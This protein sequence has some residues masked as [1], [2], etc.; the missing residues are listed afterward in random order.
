ML[1]VL[2]LR[3]KVS[4]VLLLAA[5]ATLVSCAHDKDTQLVSDQDRKYESTIPWNKQE[6][7]EQDGTGQVDRLNTR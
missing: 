4:V 2:D 7:W 3:K 5:A 1:G 6:R